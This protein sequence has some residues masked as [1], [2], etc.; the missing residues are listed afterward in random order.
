[1]SL[2]FIFLPKD[3]DSSK[4]IILFKAANPSTW[5]AT[6]LSKSMKSKN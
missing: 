2:E 4:K 5:C 1:L 6:F 3:S